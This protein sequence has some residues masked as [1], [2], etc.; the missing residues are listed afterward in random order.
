MIGFHKVS[1]ILN[2]DH[3]HF[4]STTTYNGDRY[5]S[6]G[7]GLVIN[8]QS[9]V[10]AAENIVVVKI[11]NNL[12]SQVEG[13]NSYN[14][15]PGVLLLYILVDDSHSTMQV[16]VKQTNFSSASY[17][18]GWAAENGMI[19]IRILSSRDPYIEFNGVK[20]ISNDFQPYKFPPPLDVEYKF[21]AVLS[22]TS[23]S[24]SIVK[25][26]LCAF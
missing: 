10:K 25:M 15:K 14:N 11:I 13:I 9:N 7:T 20:V 24:F 17:D 4:L 12:F 1:G 19:W 3:V 22:I 21:A 16:F 5:L 26:E 23:K 6:L 2:I 18:P 8:Q